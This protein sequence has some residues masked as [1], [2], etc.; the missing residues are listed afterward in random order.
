MRRWLWVCV[1]VLAGCSQNASG[2]LLTLRHEEISVDQYRVVVT[3]GAAAD[4]STRLVPDQPKSL[5]SGTRLWLEASEAWKKSPIVVSV[6]GLEQGTIVARRQKTLNVRD[7][8]NE[9]TLTLEPYLCNECTAGER[10]C[11]AD[12]VQRC[13]MVDG[14]ARWQSPTACPVNTPFCSSGACAA[15]CTDECSASEARCINGQRELCADTDSD[16]CLEWG[17]AGCAADELCDAGACIKSC[18]GV[19]CECTVGQTQTC[20]DVGQC[21]NGSRACVNGSFGECQW[22]IGPSTEVCDGVDNN[23]DGTVDN[24][25]A[26]TLC[27]EQDGVCQGA[28][29]TCGGTAGWQACTTANFSAHHAAYEGT[30]ATCDGL[31][32]DCDGTVDNGLIAPQCPEQRGVCAGAMQACD[33]AS[34]WQA[35]SAGVYLAHNT[36]YQ[37]T[38][39]AC[40]GLDNDCDGSVDEG[41]PQCTPTTPVI[42]NSAGSVGDE[43]GLAIDAQGAVHITYFDRVT[44]DLLYTNNTSG[45]FVAQAVDTQGVVGNHPV[46]TL[47]NQGAVHTSYFD[48]TNDMLKYATNKTGA[49][50]TQTVGNGWD[51]SLAVDSLGRVHISHYHNYGGHLNYTTNESGN[52]VNLDLGTGWHSSLALDA[53]GAVHISYCEYTVGDLRYVTNK[54]GA[55]VHQTLDSVGDLGWHTSLALDAQGAIHIAYYD[56]TNTKLKYITNKSGSFVKSTID[57]SA[58]VGRYS[59]MALDSQGSVHVA[60]YDKTNGDLR[61]ATNASGTFVST[62]LDTAGDVG[63]DPTLALDAQGGVHISYYDKDSDRIKYLKH[64]P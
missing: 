26:Q 29:K 60:Y 48:S 15:G 56:F 64:C 13:E 7:G 3:T 51:I 55:F 42:L 25:L 28:T 23:C 63:Y 21:T 50:V 62:S 33:G 58:D 35:C 53:Q 1:L 49:F 19:P 43:S 39:T 16:D 61:Y 40:D 8:T 30:E 38:E 36:A 17:A 46:I 14:C 52:F 5:A 45:S 22:G 18:N 10:R 31:D 12:S 47:D 41:C 11:A 2:V 34:G 20:N 44:Y 57:D 37:A 24:G 6:D 9:V 27:A 59:S 32:N 4:R 54:S